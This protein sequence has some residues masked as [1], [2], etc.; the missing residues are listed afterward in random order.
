MRQ[1]DIYICRVLGTILGKIF[2][3]ILLVK[4]IYIII[5][6]RDLLFLA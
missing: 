5:H 1:N 2:K 6:T 4:A 3:T